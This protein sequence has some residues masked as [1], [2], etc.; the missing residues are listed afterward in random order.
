MNVLI[1]TNMELCTGCNRCVRE[2]PMEVANITYQDKS[3]AIKVKINHEKCINCGHCVVACHHEARYYVDDTERFFND[4]ANGTSISLIAAPA[5]RTNIP[6]WKKLFTYLKNIGVNKIYDVSLG[7]DICVWAHI[8][9]IDAS[10]RL[11]TQPCPA[12]VTYC[13]MYR[14]E[15]LENLSPIHS[16]MACTSIYMRKYEKLDDPIAALSPC[17]AKSAEFEKTGLT[18]YNVTFSKLLAHLK[19][20]KIKLPNKETE[21]DHYESGY[22]SLFPMPGGLKEN[23]EY[24]AGRKYSI[25]KAEGLNVYNVL[26]KY[27]NTPKESLPHI[28]DVLNCH[29]GCSIGTGCFGDVNFFEVNRTIE[30]G[31]KHVSS[32]YKKKYFDELY[33]KYDGL[34]SLSHFMRGYTADA[35]PVPEV[36]DAQIAE[37]YDLLS[38]T[39][40]VKQ[41]VDCGAC[42]SD[43]CHDM[44][45]K[46]ALGVNIPI[47]CIVKTMDDVRTEQIKNIEANEQF[48][49]IEKMREA[50]ER[51]RV[52]LDA[53]PLSA[54]FWD[55]DYKLVDCNQE[56]VKLFNMPSKSEYMK[57]YP[58][59]TPDYQPDGGNSKEALKHLIDKTFE[60]GYHRIEWM[61]QTLDGDPMPVEFTLVRVG[62]KGQQL[63][64]GYC[65]D[66]RE[67]KRMMQEIEEAQTTTSAIFGSNPQIN[68]LFNSDFEAVECNPAAVSFMEFDS[69][70]EALFGFLDKMTRSTPTFQS[71]GQP[72]VSIGEK[73]VTAVKKGN[74]KFD[75]ELVLSGQR[76]NLHVEFIR[77][78]YEDGFGVVAYVIDITNIRERELEL[79]RARQLNELQVAKL[80]LIV[81]AS[82]IGLWEMEIIKNNPT[83]S[84]NTFMWSDEFRQM[85]GF[86]NIADFPNI[87]SSWS[88]RLHPEEKA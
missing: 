75:T 16:P 78:P 73:L 76:H 5:I 61:R 23:I 63:V 56:A 64:A 71:N 83:K 84:D 45:R 33:T 68:I 72:S 1:E 86:S 37:A 51:M 15:L 38:K 24:F 43:T 11:I 85:L 66:L 81:K 57:M 14:P 69:K 35:N 39:D 27:A 49:M 55:K 53:T 44:A 67:H 26:D 65:R 7:A 3:G 74:V 54:H 80:D 87:L 13:E 6:E 42:G 46:I 36:T 12:I 48:A 22:G 2:C 21:F 28:F 29:D 52:M 82:K 88:D 70:D 4:L 41:H 25:D 31:R 20:N 60:D 30:T 40:D 79:D 34:F 19:N 18:E 32:T 47:N 10:S 8:R 50:D 58:E 17:I 62:H 77:I 9:H 59:L